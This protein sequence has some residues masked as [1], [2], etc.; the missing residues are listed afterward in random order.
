MKDTALITIAYVPYLEDKIIEVFLRSVK[1]KCSKHLREVI[2]IYKS[3]EEPF[4][5]TK[6]IGKLTIRHIAITRHTMLPSVAFHQGLKYTS[7]PYIILSDPDI[8]I[9]KN[10]FDDFYRRLY[11]EFDLNIIGCSHYS[12]ERQ[13]YQTFPTHISLLM[14]QS[15]MPDE[16]FSK[17]CKIRPYLAKDLNSSDNYKVIEG[18]RYLLGG[19]MPGRYKEFPLPSGVFDEG[20]NLYLWDKDNG[21][22]ALTF[23]AKDF[24]RK[25]T[26]FSIYRTNRLHTNFDND[27][28]IKPEK[29]LKH[30]ARS[31]RRKLFGSPDE[32]GHIK[33]RSVIADEMLVE[34]KKERYDNMLI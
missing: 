18:D 19:A 12:I 31:R 9:C 1:Q 22:R 4:E 33:A 14:H 2:V 21:S 30:W 7:C 16:E 23:I 28:K 5:V 27:I 15:K 13:A 24:V 26:A 3:E 29:L 10:E 6:N 11:E 8:V 25:K 34:L 20:C 32:G 17:K